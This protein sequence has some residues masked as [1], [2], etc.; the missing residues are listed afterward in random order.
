MMYD[1][2]YVP[3]MLS[4][5]K[6]SLVAVVSTKGA[7]N[8]H[9]SVHS[10]RKFWKGAIRAKNTNV[11]WLGAAQTWVVLKPMLEGPGPQCPRSLAILVLLGR[12]QHL[13]TFE[14]Q[15]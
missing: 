4:R 9:L 12:C 5:S 11:W 7:N 14:K 13:G 10:T 1:I 8:I 3:Y 6:A 2:W 15:A